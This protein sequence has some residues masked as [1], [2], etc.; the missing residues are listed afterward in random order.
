M[1]CDIAPETL[2]SLLYN[3]TDP[4]EE[5]ILR[6]HLKNCASCQA[7]FKELTQTTEIL[8]KWEDEVP[9]LKTVFIQEPV[10]RWQ[11]FRERIWNHVGARLA[12]GL[13]VLASAAVI[14]LFLFNFHASYQDG[15]W[16]IAF[17]K[18][19]MTES[20]IDARINAT[21]AKWQNQQNDQLVKLIQE[22]EVRQQQ[23][24]TL[25]LNEYAKQQEQ[26]RNYDLQWVGQNLQGLQRQTEGRY[27]QTSTLIN[28]LIRQS[29]TT[30]PQP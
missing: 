11:S 7:V 14:L 22:S 1:K 17:G 20:Q 19:T 6:E 10:S 21:L 2:V 15:N 3:E 29:S 5:S 24:M 9:A 12:W 23:N 30:Q 25:T 18:S 27:Y 8:E 13:P 16:H 28:D 26:K 4:R